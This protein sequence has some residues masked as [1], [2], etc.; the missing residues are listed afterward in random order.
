MSNAILSWRNW[1]AEY[2]TA[3]EVS[4]SFETNAPLSNLL[5]PRT[6]EL[7]IATT[8]GV[9]HRFNVTWSSGSPE[10]AGRPVGI[11]AL[12]N[13]N[14]VELTGGGAVVLEMYDADGHIYQ[15]NTLPLTNANSGFQ[16]HLFI[17]TD[18]YVAPFDINRVVTIEILVDDTAICG[19]KDP[20]T[21]VITPAP[22]QAGGLWAGPAWR[23]DNGVRFDGW[24]QGITEQR[25]M[26]RSIGGQVY[27]SPEARARRMSMEFSLL[28]EREVYSADLVNQPSLQQMA[29]WCGVSRPLI[30][31]PIITD[32]ELIYMQGIYGYLDGDSS[33][34]LRDAAYDPVADEKGRSYSAALTVTEAL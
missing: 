30:A 12:L 32:A 13:H 14:I 28:H 9:P 11:V 27:A 21:G 1:C 3:T 29:A 8:A 34:A 5:T 15:N 19:T 26:V 31:L 4:G 24:G 2:G 22:F 7:A 20:Y 16:S 23:P 17:I 6:G 10:T 18:D 33:W 25:R